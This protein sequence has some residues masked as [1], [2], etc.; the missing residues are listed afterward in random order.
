MSGFKRYL[1]PFLFLSAA[2]LCLNEQFMSKL[3][4]AVNSVL[5]SNFDL[6]Y[7][8]QGFY[9]TGLFLLAAGLMQLFPATEE[10]TFRLRNYFPV[11]ILTGIYAFLLLNVKQNTPVFDEYSAI[12]NFICAHRDQNDYW[13]SFTLLFHPYYE[14]RIPVPMI[15]SLSGLLFP[16][17]VFAFNFLV[18]INVLM[19]VI[20]GY[21]LYKSSEI[22]KSGLQ[23]FPSLLLL[24]LNAEYIM[25]TGNSLSGLC[26]NGVLLFSVLCLKQLHRAERFRWSIVIFLLLAVYSFGNGLLLLPLLFWMLIRKKVFQGKWFFI[27]LLT[28][29]AFSYLLAYQPQSLESGDFDLFRLMVFIPVFLGSSFQ[30]FYTIHLPLLMG[31]LV[32]STFVLACYH[33]YDQK[34]PVLFH[35]L[36]FLILTACVTAW[37]RHA[38]REEAPLRLRYGVFSTFS[39]YIS[40]LII[41]ELFP[42]LLKKVKSN[43]FFYGFLSYNLLA[44]FFFYPETALLYKYNREMIQSFRKSGKIEHDTPYYIRGYQPELKCAIQHGLLKYH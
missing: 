4:M 17:D 24:I 26:Y 35:S 21:V 11:F 1:V 16:G 43:V 39:I 44:G 9:Y 10:K 34:N 12:I 40:L 38:F 19:L 29:T 27:I 30:F 23:L 8:L 25:S 2:S 33:R 32:L 3:L 7:R 5:H 14:C 36:L 31:L 42:E 13:Q 15:I 18:L 6:Y 41:L 28:L 22:E 20:T 37:F